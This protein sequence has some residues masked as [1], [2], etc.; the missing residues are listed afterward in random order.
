MPKLTLYKSMVMG[1]DNATVPLLRITTTFSG[2]NDMFIAGLGSTN[3]TTFSCI[4]PPPAFNTVLRQ[5]LN[6]FTIL[7]SQGANKPRCEQA[8]VQTR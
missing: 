6:P 2:P 8:E 4:N 5:Q 1:P 7:V 3:A